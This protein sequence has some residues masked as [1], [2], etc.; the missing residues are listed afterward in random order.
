MAIRA[1]ERRIAENRSTTMVNSVR[2]THKK[3]RKGCGRCKR[4]HIKVRSSDLLGKPL[5]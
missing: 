3:S 1:S 2:K 5:A 4:R